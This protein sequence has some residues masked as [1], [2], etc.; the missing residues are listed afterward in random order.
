MYASDIFASATFMQA[1][2]AHRYKHVHVM[3]FDLSFS[4]YICMF[5]YYCMQKMYSL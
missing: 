3:S 2:F 1:I 4:I 5:T